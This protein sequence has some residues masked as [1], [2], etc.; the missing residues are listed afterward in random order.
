[1]SEDNEKKHPEN[2]ETSRDSLPAEDRAGE[3]LEEALKDPGLEAFIAS[4]RK[5]G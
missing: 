4:A 1:M 3:P 2:E 5:P